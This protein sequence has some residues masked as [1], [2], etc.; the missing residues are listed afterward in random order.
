MSAVFRLL[1]NNYQIVLGETE[2]VAS[3]PSVGAASASETSNIDE[4]QRHLEDMIEQLMG[5]AE[6]PPKQVQGMP[7]R[8]FDGSSSFLKAFVVS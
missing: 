6:A 2:G 1:A 5:M 8:W 4:H 3:P 7:D